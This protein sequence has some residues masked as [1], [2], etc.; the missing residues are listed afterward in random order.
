MESEKAYQL[1]DSRSCAADQ[2]D[3]AFAPIFD[4]KAEKAA[5]SLLK[6]CQQVRCHLTIVS[7]QNALLIWQRRAMYYLY[8]SRFSRRSSRHDCRRRYLTV[9]G[10]ASSHAALV[11]RQMGKVCVCGSRTR[12]RPSLST[13]KVAGKTFKG[14]YLS[15][16]GT[17]GEVYG[18]ELSTAPSEILQ[19]L[20]DKSLKPAKANLQELRPADGLVKATKLKRQMDSKAGI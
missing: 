18:G 20:I 6:D 10:G 9:R 15:I 19:V 8:A 16:N 14:D 13:P 3:Q 4:A 7:M 12:D 11:A 2:L 17:S 5:A 1:E